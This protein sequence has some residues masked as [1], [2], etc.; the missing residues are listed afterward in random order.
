MKILDN[1]FDAFFSFLQDYSIED[2]QKGFVLC[3][4]FFSFFSCVSIFY[5]KK[6]VS[7]LT[8]SVNQINIQTSQVDML[9]KLNE[10]ILQQETA[11]QSFLANNQLPSNLKTFLDQLI[12]KNNINCDSGWKEG[13]KTS[14]WFLDENF[15]EEV[16]VLNIKNIMPKDLFE[17]IQEIYK[18][19]SV[20]LRELI[21][22]KS[23]SALSAKLSFSTRYKKTA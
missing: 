2:I 11:E 3:F 9:K 5:I 14:K 1:L 8:K 13:S 22:T 18:Q 4:V 17:F 20:A 21:T 15:E 12:T 6:N 19:P 16:V 7:A 23:V 10:K